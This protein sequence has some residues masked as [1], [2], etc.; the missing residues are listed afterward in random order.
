M[1]WELYDVTMRHFLH[2]LEIDKWY[3]YQ[4]YIPIANEINICIARFEL[5]K[6]EKVY[7]HSSAG[8][9]STVTKRTAIVNHRTPDCK[10]VYKE[11]FDTFAMK[12]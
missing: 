11:A 9:T 6:S 8:Q 3:K 5:K 1:N 4:D 7:K 2:Y 10:K 12:T